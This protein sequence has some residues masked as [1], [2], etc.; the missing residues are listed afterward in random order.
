MQIST[1]IIFLQSGNS[2]HGN[3]CF[4][5]PI[6][7]SYSNI[8]QCLRDRIQIY[9]IGFPSFS[10]VWLLFVSANSDLGMWN[11]DVGLDNIFDS[12]NNGRLASKMFFHL[13]ARQLWRRLTS[14]SSG[15]D[16]ED[17][18][19]Q[20]HLPLYIQWYA[21][22]FLKYDPWRTCFWALGAC[23]EWNFLGP[24]LNIFNQISLGNLQFSGIPSCLLRTWLLI[25]AVDGYQL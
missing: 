3:T 4:D 24:I 19:P 21:Q 7:H 5:R 22:S 8:R 16:L 11:F 12:G 9:C 2:D 1:L 23:W 15:T 20:V 25:I 6:H 10:P 17:W 18:V 13:L 14:S